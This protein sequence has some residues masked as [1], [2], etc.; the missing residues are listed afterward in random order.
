MPFSPLPRARFL[1]IFQ[2]KAVLSVFSMASVP[3]STKNRW[4]EW[5]FGTASAEKVSTNRAKCSV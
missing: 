5:L 2:S 3:P 4:S 1:R